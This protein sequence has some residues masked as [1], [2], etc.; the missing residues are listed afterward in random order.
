MKRSAPSFFFFAVSHPAANRMKSLKTIL[1]RDFIFPRSSINDGTWSDPRWA[2]YLEVLLMGTNRIQRKMTLHKCKFGF[3]GN[4]LFTS[5][6]E[7]R[8]PAFL[9]QQTSRVPLV[10]QRAGLY[11]IDQLHRIKYS[12]I[13]I[14][15]CAWV[16][17]RRL[18]T[19]A[20]A[21]ATNKDDIQAAIWLSCTQ[22]LICVQPWRDVLL[23]FICS[24]CCRRQPLC[25]G[26][27][28]ASRAE[29]SPEIH[30]A[31]SQA[32]AWLS[33]SNR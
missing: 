6:N 11:T 5:A 15:G 27:A 33:C 18:Q 22:S 13:K 7:I 2:I 26:P 9:P 25:L 10:R 30:L 14:P 19:S 1:S 4:E 31:E 20:E 8:P 21:R 29:R 24:P 17:C 16:R 12:R 32:A 28:S 23:W 3:W